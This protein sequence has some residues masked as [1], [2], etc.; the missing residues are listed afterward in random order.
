MPL[1]HSDCGFGGH[2][3]EQHLR[4]TGRRAAEFATAFGAESWASLAGLWHDLGKFSPA[5]QA[6]LRQ[7]G[8]NVALAADQ[9]PTRRVDHSTAGAIHA[10]QQLC[11][12]GRL[13]AYIIAGHH[14]GLPDWATADAAGA[15]LSQRLKQVVLLEAVLATQPPAAVLASTIL[16]ALP[17]GTDL[18]LFIRM[19]FSALIDADRLD[20]EAFCN[21]EVAAQR[22]TVPSLASLAD[23]H[24]QYLAALMARAPDTAVNRYRQRLLDACRHAAHQEPG[25]F[26]LTAPTGLGKTFAGL[27][28]ALHHA[29]RYGKRRVIYVAPYTSIIE[30]T[31]EAFRAALGAEAVLEHHSNLDPANE[32]SATTAHRLAAENW[33]AA[34]IATTAVQFFESLFSA[35]PGRCRKLHRIAGAVVFLDEAQLLPPDF[36]R[37]ILRCLQQLTTHYGV[38]VVLSTATQPALDPR[39]NSTPPFDGLRG[40]HGRRE[41]VADPAGLHAVMR[42]VRVKLPADLDVRTAWPAL[43]QELTT[44]PSVLCI[45][46]RRA[47]ARALHQLLPP[48]SVHLSALMCGAHRADVLRDVRTRMARGES[49]RVVST[50]LVEA[51][52]DLDFPIVFRALAGLNSLA[53]AAGRCNREGKLPAGDLRI[54]VP[55]N[56]P[57]P[58]H[59]RQAA[60]VARLLLRGNPPDPFTPE[61]FRRFFE[62]LY[63]LKGD[64]LDAKHVCDLLP[65]QPRDGALAFRTAGERFRMIPDDEAPVLVPY[66]AEGASV[67]AAFAALAGTDAPRAGLYRRAQ[68]YIVGVPRRQLALLLERGIIRQLDVDSWAAIPSAYHSDYGFD[69]TAYLP[70]D[71]LIL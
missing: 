58:G 29:V 19:L 42:R 26:S 66:R 68:R 64:A 16:N 71:S 25:L 22:P 3:L 51:G 57:P 50:Q 54:F 55:P 65:A 28:F 35:H 8:E 53:Q 13:L 69:M 17:P 63:W 31:A 46:D 34:V 41:I 43:A 67:V 21:P 1:A 36:L 23:A 6:Y 14:A 18:S 60:G 10:E 7:A 48:G 20:T 38:T 49:L 33:D 37:P 39:P 9:A 15:A 47:D 61:M 12:R 70:P 40:P 4:D 5:F 24:D 27:A 62:Q 44:C 32:V 2:D 30:Q 59:L 52:V 56:D 11:G 45:V